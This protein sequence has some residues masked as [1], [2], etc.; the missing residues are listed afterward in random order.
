MRIN[1][2]KMHGCGNDYIYINCF[3]QVIENPNMLAIEMSERHFSVG[4]D[5]IVLIEKSDVAD[6][7]M[8]MFNA[9]G[10]EGKMCG[11]AIRCIGKYLYDNQLVLKKEIDI[12]TLSG[13]KHLVLFV[14]DGK[15]SKVSVNMGFANFDS[16]V[17]PT[18]LDHEMINEEC[19]IKKNTYNITAVSMGNPHAVIYQDHIGSLDLLKIGGFFENN[20]IFP[21]RV[22]TEFVKIIDKNHLKMRVWERGSGETYACGTGACAVVASSVRN[23]I[24]NP[25]E[26][27]Y[28]EL[29][30]GIL[31][32]SCSDNYEI[33]MTGPAKKVYDGVYEYE[34]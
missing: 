1:F 3:D 26:I 6:A 5:G 17:I 16:K 2:T 29:L 33:T 9:D 12:E 4:S 28:V 11:N 22:N 30:G 19:V 25:N 18:T 21:E 7:K 23:G 34:Y 14:E 8:R 20:P 15:V 13:I 10:S 31:E 27:I 32:I 24:C